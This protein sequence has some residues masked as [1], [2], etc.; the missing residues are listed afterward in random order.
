VDQGTPRA[1]IC[2][3]FV[4]SQSTIKR[5]LTLKRKADDVKPKTIPGRPSKKGAA[6]H[7]GLLPQLEAHPDATLDEHCQFWETT[8]GIRVSSATMSRAIR[9]L[10]WTRKK[11]TLR[12]SEQSVFLSESGQPVFLESFSNSSRL[13]RQSHRA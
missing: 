6:L 9:R 5:Y 12:A 1:E 7:V 11:K 3:I 8:H 13:R 2:K 4:V 10:N